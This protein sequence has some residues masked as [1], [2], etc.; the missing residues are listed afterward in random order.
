MKLKVTFL[1]ASMFVEH[2]VMKDFKIKF[3]K[4]EIQSF[5]TKYPL[6]SQLLLLVAYKMSISHM[7]HQLVK[8]QPDC[9]K[10]IMVHFI[11]F[12]LKTTR[13]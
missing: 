4:S 11:N 13:Y 2:S 8:K 7:Q 1:F 6:L 3:I 10:Q 9:L 12:T 5:N